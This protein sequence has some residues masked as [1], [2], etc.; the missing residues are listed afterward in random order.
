MH[1]YDIGSKKIL[2]SYEIYFDA[3]IGTIGK[4]FDGYEKYFIFH[5]K[6]LA[7][8]LVINVVAK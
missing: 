2:I 5:G 7:T 8:Q 4:Y 3:R 1:K 6:D